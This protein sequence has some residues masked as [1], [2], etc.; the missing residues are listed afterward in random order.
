VNL[1]R[2]QERSSDRRPHM[3]RRI[4]VVLAAAALLLATAASVAR[5]DDAPNVAG[6]IAQAVCES[7]TTFPTFTSFGDCVQYVIAGGAVGVRLGALDDEQI[8]FSLVI[9]NGAVTELAGVNN[10]SCTAVGTIVAVNGQEITLTLAPGESDSVAIPS[11][12]GGIDV[13]RFRADIPQARRGAFGFTTSFN[14]F[15]AGAGC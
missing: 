6:T 9:Q 4:C 5:A 15:G 10:T 11:E 8:I 14:Q 2:G 1:V 3:S 13:T 12:L 7:Q